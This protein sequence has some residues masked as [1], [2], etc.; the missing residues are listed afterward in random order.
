[1]P[2]KSDE[3]QFAGLFCLQESLDSAVGPK[4]PIGIFESN[5]FVKLQQIDMVGFEAPQGLVDLFGG[6]LLG[7]PV[8]LGH[9]ECPVAIAVL[10]R[11]PRHH[12]AIKHLAFIY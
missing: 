3:S 2:R 6:F 9:E 1:M 10:Q 5:N 11:F 8:D 7:S 12:L 4:D